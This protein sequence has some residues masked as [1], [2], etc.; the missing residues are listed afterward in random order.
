MVHGPCIMRKMEKMTFEQVK[1]VVKTMAKVAEDNEAYF[2][3]LD[4]VMG[5][6]DFGVSLATGFR[7]VMNNWDKYDMTSIGSF[8]LGITTA[9]SGSTGGCSGPVWGTLFMR[10]G[11]SFR[12]KTELTISE[13]S[14]GLQNAIEGI[15]KRGGAHLGDKTLLDALD[16]IVKSLDQ[17]AADGKSMNEAL[18]AAAKAAYD[19]REGT[20]QWIAKRG[21]Q[22]FTGDR[23]IGTYDPGI[24]AIG[25][26]AVAIAAALK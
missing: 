16:A 4:G 1:T 21:R 11:M 26:M 18:G 13:I 3:E 25:D 5:D 9:I 23:S 8:L 7:A 24:V 20:K 22:S 2:S 14:A 17:S 19:T 12:D 10:C 6:A 15:M